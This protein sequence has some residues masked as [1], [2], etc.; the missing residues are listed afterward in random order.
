MFNAGKVFIWLPNETSDIVDGKLL[1]VIKES[2]NLIVFAF[3]PT[4][5]KVVPATVCTPF[6]H[7]Y[8]CFIS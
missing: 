5:L 4:K 2:G 8:I 7:F 3:F 1:I 6:C